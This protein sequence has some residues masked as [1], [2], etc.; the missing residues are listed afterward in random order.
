M[1]LDTVELVMEFEDEFEIT[2]SSVRS[3]V[4][5]AYFRMTARIARVKHRGR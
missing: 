2:V 3:A 5:A 4:P 1:G